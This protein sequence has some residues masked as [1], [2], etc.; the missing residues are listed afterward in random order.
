MALSTERQEEICDE[1]TQ[2]VLSGQLY[3]IEGSSE[4]LRDNDVGLTEAW[5]IRRFVPVPDYIEGGYRVSVDL[6]R[7]PLAA[8]VD[9]ETL[10]GYLS[11]RMAESKDL[12]KEI[13]ERVEWDAAPVS[14]IDQFTFPEA[15]LEE[16]ILI[17][18]VYIRASI[19]SYEPEYKPD[20]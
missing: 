1:I 17:Q 13:I 18:Y 9:P 10:K 6:S 4:I 2:K 19:A 20:F 3:T 14:S 8:S 16:S 7:I 5:G 12:R 15:R 11:E